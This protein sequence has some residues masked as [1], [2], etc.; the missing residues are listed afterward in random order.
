MASVIEWSCKNC[1]E[2]I[3]HTEVNPQKRRNRQIGHHKICFKTPKTIAGWPVLPYNGQ[4]YCPPKG[5]GNCCGPGL[6][7]T[8][9]T[10]YQE[11]LLLP[12]DELW[13]YV[14]STFAPTSLSS[15]TGPEAPMVQ[16]TSDANKMGG[17]AGPTQL[18]DPACQDS[19]LAATVPSNVHDRMDVDTPTP[20]PSILVLPYSIENDADTGYVSHSTPSPPPLIAPLSPDLQQWTTESSS[21]IS[22]LSGSAGTPA[23]QASH[24]DTL[25]QLTNINEFEIWGDHLVGHIFDNHRPCLPPTLKKSTIILEVEKVRAR[26]QPI[27]SP[28]IRVALPQRPIPPLPW[29]REPSVGYKCRLCTYVAGTVR[30]VSTHGSKLHGPGQMCISKNDQAV[31]VQVL[32]AKTQYFEVHPMLQNVSKEDL[33]SK[34]YCALPAQYM[35]GA[36]VDGETVDA[37][38]LGD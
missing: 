12:R 23:P 24:A 17:P 36:F 27:E 15:L 8:T 21:S 31:F 9:Q 28:S 37:A 6:N 35:N 11:A 32:F 1:Q 38:D 22:A 20:T 10:V 5:K 2:V 14:E 30:T 16:P 26:L 18:L 33:F 13:Q 25:C 3:Q 7:E 19:T 34:F 29:L 4:Y